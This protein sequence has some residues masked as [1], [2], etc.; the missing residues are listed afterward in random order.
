MILYII[1]IWLGM[2]FL[3]GIIIVL[4]DQKEIKVGD[5]GFI[6]ALTLAGTMGLIITLVSVIIVFID[7]H[8]DKVIF[9]IK[10]K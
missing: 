9:S 6:F 2:G 5:I 7:K 3:S 10:K 8:K 1:L 4:H